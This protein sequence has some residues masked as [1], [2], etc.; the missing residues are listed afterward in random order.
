[1]S[2]KTIVV[3]LFQGFPGYS[4]MFIFLYELQHNVPNFIKPA[5]MFLLGLY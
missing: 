5:V 4:C 1:M 2:G 3:I